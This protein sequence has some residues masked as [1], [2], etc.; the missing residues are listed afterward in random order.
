MARATIERYPLLLF[1]LVIGLPHSQGAVVNF[2][3]LSDG[4]IFTSQIPGLS[5]TNGIILTAGISLN[6][7]EFPPASGSNV[8]S[9]NGGEMT[10]T[11]TSPALSVVGRFTYLVPITL[12]A[13]DGGNN[14]VGQVTSAFGSNLAL[15]GDPGSSPNE[16]LQFAFAGINNITITGDPLGGS[17]TLDDLEYTTTVVPEPSSTIPILLTAVGA[18][19]LRRKHIIP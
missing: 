2:D 16:L 8:V 6:E 10:I 17:F 9:D 5:F 18:F 13:F 3:S 11:F 4:E 14:Q 12:T 19:L 15:S 1:L 7:F